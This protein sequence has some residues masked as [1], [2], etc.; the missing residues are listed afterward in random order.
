MCAGDSRYR[1][2]TRYVTRCYGYRFSC[3]SGRKAKHISVLNVNGRFVYIYVCSVIELSESRC[4]R[5]NMV[6]ICV[7][8]GLGYRDICLVYFNACLCGG[9]CSCRFAGVKECCAKSRGGVCKFSREFHRCSV[10]NLENYRRG[11]VIRDNNT[12]TRCSAN[13]E[14]TAVLN[15]CNGVCIKRTFTANNKVA[16]FCNREHSRTGTGRYGFA[17]KVDNNS[18]CNVDRFC[19]LNICAKF[20]FCFALRSRDC[21]F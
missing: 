8:G 19:C 17:V 3:I 11:V 16:A 13:S 2:Y 5:L 12:V 1:R 7:R 18:I 15:V 10:C 20:N 9:L 14:L 4:R 21:C 6:A